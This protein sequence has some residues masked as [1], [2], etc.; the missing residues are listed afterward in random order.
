MAY[1]DYYSKFHKKQVEDLIEEVS[2]VV[3]GDSIEFRASQIASKKT[4]R[5]LFE[6]KNGNKV[7]LSANFKEFPDCCGTCTID[8]ILSDYSGEEF[9]MLAGL[10]LP[11]LIKLFGYS[12]AIYITASYQKELIKMFQ[13]LGWNS[14]DLGV[15]SRTGSILTA[16]GF[17]CEPK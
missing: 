8:Y 12:S 1:L 5:I 6:V 13:T 10:L 7:I 9:N 14:M 11:R 2:K 3:K 17:N 16:W 4:E 15:N